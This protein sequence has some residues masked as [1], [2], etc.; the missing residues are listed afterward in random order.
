MFDSGVFLVHVLYCRS[1]YESLWNIVK[2]GGEFSSSGVACWTVT[3][4]CR[5]FHLTLSTSGR[6]GGRHRAVLEDKS[7]DEER[8]GPPAE[9]KDDARMATWWKREICRQ[10]SLLIVRE[11]LEECQMFGNCQEIAKK[12]PIVSEKS[13]VIFMIHRLFR[14]S[15]AN[16]WKLK[17]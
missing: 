16:N 1:Y 14:G 13:A 6:E 12:L 2:I 4:N 17:R 8:T 10:G 11:A 7:G 5:D 3:E 15:Q 9:D